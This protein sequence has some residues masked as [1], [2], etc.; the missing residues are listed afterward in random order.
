MRLQQ[1]SAASRLYR[2]PLALAAEA[3]Y[4]GLTPYDSFPTIRRSSTR[5]LTPD[6]MYRKMATP[7]TAEEILPLVAV[8]SAQERARFLRLLSAPTP[9]N[10]AYAA[11]APSDSEFSSDDDI[12]SWDAEGWE[13]FS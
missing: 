1:T 6:R 8:L 5:E 9:A 2:L 12:L 3:R 10:E 4:V 11:R 13:A 7:L